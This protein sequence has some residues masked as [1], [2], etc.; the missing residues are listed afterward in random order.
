MII[1]FPFKKAFLSTVGSERLIAISA[2]DG[3]SAGYGLKI[4]PGKIGNRFGSFQ[5]IKAP[6]L[7]T[8]AIR[9]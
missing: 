9:Q 3:G 2:A 5:T 1:F 6:G 4:K 8:Q 7:P